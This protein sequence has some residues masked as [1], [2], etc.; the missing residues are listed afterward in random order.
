MRIEA[1]ESLGNLSPGFRLSRKFNRE[2]FSF[3]GSVTGTLSISNFLVQN[4][5]QAVLV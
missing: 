5:Q 4:R 3:E 2:V 1:R